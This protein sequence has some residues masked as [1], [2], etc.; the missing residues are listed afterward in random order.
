VSGRF[1]CWGRAEMGTRSFRG[2]GSLRLIHRLSY[3]KH[4]PFHNKPSLCPSIGGTGRLHEMA[5]FLSALFP[6]VTF[7]LFTFFVA[8]FYP[9]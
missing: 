6:S 4:T 1:G 8:I 5:H 3:T 2:S 9:A 7:H